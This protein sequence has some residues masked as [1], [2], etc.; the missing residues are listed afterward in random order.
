[1]APSREINLASV[2]RFEPERGQIRLKDYRMV[3]LSAAAL[4]C[5]RKELIETVGFEAAR[6]LMKRF[7]HA[8]GLADGAALA[9]RFPTASATR[10]LDYGPA[11]HALEGVARIVRDEAKSVVDLER[12]RYHIEAYWENS[13]EAE[14]HLALIGRSSEPVCWTLVGYATGHSSS[15]TGR[16]TVVA[17]TECQAMGASR[18]RFVVGFADELPELARRENPDYEPQRL[19]EMLDEL[20]RT[21]QQQR[22]TLRTNEKTISRLQST[23]T[24]EPRAGEMLGTSATL[25]RV[26]HLVRVVAPLDTTVLIRG[27]SGTGKE[28]VARAIHALSSRADKP[29][30]A[31]NCSALPETLQEAELFGFIKGAFTGAVR[32]SEGLFQSADGGT[33]FLDEVGDLSLSAQTKILRALQEGEIKR[34]GEPRA[35]KVDVR[36]LAAT[37]RDL[38]TMIRDR[39][40]RDDLYY[41]L[42]VVTIPLPPLRDRGDDALLLAQEFVSE[43]SRRFSKKIRG[44]SRASKCAIANHVWPGNVRELQNAIE[45]AVILAQGEAIEVEDLPETVLTGARRLGGGGTKKPRSTEP[46]L[47]D[48][49][50]ERERLRKALEIAG[51]NRER[52]ASILG[53]S[54]TTLWRRLRILE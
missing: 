25:N 33:L 46:A 14:Q 51:G 11:L 34:L 50:D 36:V 2:L 31:V 12:G 4:G 16:A 53:I 13:Y 5:L 17:E 43:Q 54:R 38:E 42:A 44:L 48:I 6:A 1:M 24:R 32:D 41:R 37:H 29:F 15:A 23:L 40:F 47:H 52:A 10:Q 28:L 39:T 7:G 30:V 22:Q 8:A 20:L 26:R 49:A 19:P 27:E 21:I 35:R 45:R 18:C 3:M 9:E